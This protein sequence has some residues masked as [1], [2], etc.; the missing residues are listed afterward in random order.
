ML[1]LRGARIERLVDVRELPLSRKPGFSKRALM[2]GLGHAG[3]AY[4]HL[5]AL[6]TPKAIRAEYKA[7]GG[8]EKFHQAY[9]KHLAAHADAL[10]E[11][12]A[13]SRAERV[14]ILCVEKEWAS[15]HR[16]VIAEKMEARGWRVAHL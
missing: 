14:A 11:L 9:R 5:K 1:T 12:E 16:A 15:C 3:I 10:A 2:L 7:G 13:L 6:G 4:S 8:V